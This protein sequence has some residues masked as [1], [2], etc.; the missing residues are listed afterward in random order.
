[1]SEPIIHS[2][3]WVGA[4]A[5]ATKAQIDALY[6]EATRELRGALERGDRLAL[7]VLDLEALLSAHVTALAE[8]R[9]QCDRAESRLHNFKVALTQDQPTVSG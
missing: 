2:P 9:A 5:E 1:M 7:R 6:H 4:A 8:V 3:P